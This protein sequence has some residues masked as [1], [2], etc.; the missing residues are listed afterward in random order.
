MFVSL[1]HHDTTVSF[2]D[3][4]GKACSVFLLSKVLV[5]WL[6]YILYHVNNVSIKYCFIECS[7][8]MMC[9]EFWQMLSLH[10]C[11]NHIIFLLYSVYMALFMAVFMGFLPLNHTCITEI[12]YSCLSCIVFY[13]LLDS[14]CWCYIYKFCINIYN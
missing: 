14:I 9:A 11:S 6:R 7:F 3:H 5:Y 12:N 13:V 10:L 4:N 8:I 1:W 2:L